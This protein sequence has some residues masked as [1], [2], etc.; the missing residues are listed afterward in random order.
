MNKAI[1]N[2]AAAVALGTEKMRFMLSPPFGLDFSLVA[3]YAR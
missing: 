3:G 2:V 1:A